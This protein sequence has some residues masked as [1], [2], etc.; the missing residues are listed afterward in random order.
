MTQLLI[1]IQL[2]WKIDLI[3]RKNKRMFV[4]E[5]QYFNGSP[6][7]EKNQSSSLNQRS[8][9]IAPLDFCVAGQYPILLAGNQPLMQNNSYFRREHHSRK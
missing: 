5:I 2:D 6:I 8:A 9:L 3:L 4:C 1:S 7:T